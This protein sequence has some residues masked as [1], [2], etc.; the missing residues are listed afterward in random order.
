[1]RPRK[2]P[3]PHPDDPQYAF[4][5]AAR[6]LSLRPR[7]VK[8]IEDYL[9]KKDF[10]PTATA[11]AIA[12]LKDLKFLNDEEFGKNFM[13]GRQVYKGRSK[14]FVKYELKQKGLAENVINE[15]TEDAQ[16]DLTTAKAFVEHKKRIYSHLDK[17]EFKEKMMRLLQSR[18]FS[19]DIIKSV[20]KDY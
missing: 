4:N 1:M 8:E 11:A 9:I 19:F 13:R 3:N 14:Y 12:R 16:D 20:L 15:V 10:T 5:R 18:G 7:S 2:F 17:L 6:Y